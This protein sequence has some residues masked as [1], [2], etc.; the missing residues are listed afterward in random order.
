MV[1]AYLV[2]VELGKRIFFAAERRPAAHP[3]GRDQAGRTRVSR[4]AARFS[5]G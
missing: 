1:L 2:L 4:R 5:V 3:D